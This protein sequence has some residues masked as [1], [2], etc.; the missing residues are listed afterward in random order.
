[1]ATYKAHL[2][3]GAQGCDYSI[4]C[5]EKVIELS[6]T[7]FEVAVQELI[8]KIKEEYS[9]EERQIESAKLFEVETIGILDIKS[10]YAKIESDRVIE[11]QILKEAKERGEFERLKAKFG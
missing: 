4:G 9:H 11:S 5:G 6:A 2:N 3:Q 1:M 8:E 10:I 7:T